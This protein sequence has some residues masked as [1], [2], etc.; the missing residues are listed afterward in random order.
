MSK[1]EESPNSDLVDSVWLPAEK[2]SPNQPILIIQV[3]QF[4]SILY[5]HILKLDLSEVANNFGWS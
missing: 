1:R 4:L 5:L 2:P 3:E